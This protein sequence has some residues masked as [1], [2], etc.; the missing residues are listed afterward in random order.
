MPHLAW[1][2]VG[3]RDIC[4]ANALTPTKTIAASRQW[5]FLGL[6]VIA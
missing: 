3:S 5:F 2:G 6:V 1:L 4:S